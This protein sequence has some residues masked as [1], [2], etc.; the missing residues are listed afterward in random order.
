MKCL[1]TGGAGFIGSNLAREAVER[2]WQVRLLDNFYL[3][4]S[5]N[6]SSLKRE[7]KLINGDIRD[8]KTIDAATK[9]IDYIFHQA[10][11]SSSQMFVPD[12]SEGFSVN[13]QGFA[14][15][16]FHAHKNGVQRVVY[17]S[18]SSIYGDLPTPHR[19]DMFI[20]S[21]PNHYAASKL[22]SEYLAKAHTLQQGLETVGLRYFSVYGPREERKG[23]YANM[24]SQFLW[25][26][27]REETPVIYG[28]GF[29][30]RDFTY[31]KD[32]VEAN[33]LATKKKRASGEVFN[34][35]TGRSTTINAAVSLLNKNL[36]TN[37]KPKHVRNPIKNYVCHTLADT[38]KAKNL[39]GFE[40]K[41]SLEK[42]IKILL[43]YS[44]D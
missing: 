43:S 41:T 36:G 1:V 9:G 5:E 3:G 31:V 40:A 11:V 13:V 44:E 23:K 19:E 32:I 39:L 35:G 34:I 21:C 37:L 28:D 42:G 25:G 4:S 8:R 17:A 14:N 15:L 30:T 12:P 16:L 33:F 20:K 18:T 29:Q 6:L 38:E 10:A 2:G 7:I 24:I 22:A 27:K 26:M